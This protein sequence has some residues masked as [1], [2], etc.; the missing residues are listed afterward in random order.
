MNLKH[1][2]RVFFR[3]CLML[4]FLL[5][6]GSLMILNSST[7][8]AD[9]EKGSEV[10]SQDTGDE[11][12]TEEMAKK[13]KELDVITIDNKGYKKDR[14][15]P[16][17]FEHVKHAR[18][19]AISCWECHHEYKKDQ[20]EEKPVKEVKSEEKEET[21]KNEESA[22]KEKALPKELTA[23]NIWSPW[24]ITKKCSECHDPQEKKD[25]VIKLQAAYHK[26]C[27]TCHLEKRI[28]GDDVLAY[29]K[30]TSCHK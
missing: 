9:D 11:Q 1:K 20:A 28:Y 18:E 15:D 29:R 5:I 21:V 12:M 10:M 4:I 16:A 30:C 3:V 19:Y 7:I 24:G 25:D 8:F 6:A 13:I 26:N 14:K 17:K 2:P 27:K 22:K 23:A